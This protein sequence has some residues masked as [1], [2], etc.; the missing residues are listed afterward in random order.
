MSNKGLTFIILILILLCVGT[1]GAFYLK[2]H[3]ENSLSQKIFGV[4]VAGPIDNTLNPV[5]VDNTINTESTGA[6]DS[7]VIQGAVTP[8]PVEGS[9]NNDQANNKAISDQYISDFNN[10]VSSGSTSGSSS[11]SGAGVTPPITNNPPAVVT[12]PSSGTQLTKTLQKG[13]TGAEVKI[14]QEFLIKNDYLVG[15]ADGAFGAKTASAVMAF[16]KDYKLTADGIVGPSA[17]KV[18]NELLASSQ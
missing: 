1:F 17:R 6:I 7:A 16:Q 12:P 14:L 3:P 10:A 5:P 13:S 4:S 8:K 15:T 18:I 9:T 11:S 2:I